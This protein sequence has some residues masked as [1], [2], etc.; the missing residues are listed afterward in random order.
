[1]QEVEL[2]KPW[3]NEYL[4]REIR[5]KFYLRNVAGT[6]KQFED[7]ESY[8]KQRETAKRLDTLAR[9]AYFRNNLC[10]E[11]HWLPILAME[12]AQTSQSCEN[13]DRDFTSEKV[14][15]S[16]PQRLG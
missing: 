10:Q 13:C 16:G 12:A 14:I 11:S 1:M 3:I 9:D 4:G 7:Y 6:S 8:R 5:R 2:N 15:F